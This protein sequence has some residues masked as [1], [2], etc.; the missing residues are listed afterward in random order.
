MKQNYTPLCLQ[1][2]GWGVRFFK[3]RPATAGLP[4]AAGIFNES[5]NQPHHTL[6]TL[7]IPEATNR[8]PIWLIVGASGYS[9]EAGGQ[10]AVPGARGIVL[11][12]TPPESIVANEAERPNVVT[13][14]TRKAC[15]T[16][17]ICSSS[18]GA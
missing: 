10:V 5:M 13:V 14:A 12:R 2:R 16:T 6:Q 7:L 1:E 17:A 4:A 3:N 9:A 18:I 15:K 11:R 8:E